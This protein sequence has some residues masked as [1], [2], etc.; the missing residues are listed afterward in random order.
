MPKKHN[1]IL[2][3]STPFTSSITWIILDHAIT[4]S[5]PVK[6]ERD[7]ISFVPEM[8][9]SDAATAS[10]APILSTKAWAA[11]RNMSS[12]SGETASTNLQWEK[13]EENCLRSEWFEWRNCANAHKRAEKRFNPILPTA[14]PLI[15]PL[16]KQNRQ[17]R[18]LTRK[19]L[20]VS[21]KRLFT[22]HTDYLTGAACLLV[23]LGLLQV[24]V[25][26]VVELQ[27]GTVLRPDF[28]PIPRIIL[29]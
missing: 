10:T 5:L 27:Y 12:T 29:Q 6:S 22:I 18:W 13:N 9:A 15:C 4:T 26:W 2:P 24:T 16:D 14:L 21:R 3:D 7:L 19:L 20:H 23:I 8:C 11:S 17:L 28:D 25:D 1:K